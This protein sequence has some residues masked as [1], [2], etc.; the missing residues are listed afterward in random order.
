MVDIWLSL[1]PTVLATVKVLAIV[2]GHLVGV[3]AADDRAI[4]ILAA[5]GQTAGQ[6]PLL[7]AMVVSTFGGLYL[8]LRPLSSRGSSLVLRLHC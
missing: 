7:L 4:A 1:H 2:I 5:H 3:V 8:L 6:L